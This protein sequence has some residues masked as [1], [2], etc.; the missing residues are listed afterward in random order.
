MND[1]QNALETPVF[2]ASA[3]NCR[4][5]VH[6]ILDS[7]WQD[8]IGEFRLTL[9]DEMEERTTLLT[10]F[11]PDQ[12]VLLGVLLYLDRFGLQLLKVEWM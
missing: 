3:T 2:A 12:T 7:R 11:V 8:Y 6:G 5:R 1:D 10:G 9:A 4:I